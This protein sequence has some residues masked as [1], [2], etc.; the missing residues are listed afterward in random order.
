MST[1]T[2]KMERALLAPL[3]LGCAV[4]V[5]AASDITMFVGEAKVLEEPGVRRLAVGNGRIVNASLLDDRQILLLGEQTGESSIHVW[6][7]KGG[8]TSYDVT[9]IP[10][11]ASRLLG[12]VRS[13]FGEKSKV[14]IRL[15]GDKLVLEGN[16]LSEDEA[17]R[18]AE[19]SRRYPQIVNLISRVGLEKMVYTDVRIMEIRKTTLRDLGILWNTRNVTGPQYGVI[20]DIHRGS[21]FT[22]SP[23][24]TG[25][26]D[27]PGIGIRNRIAPFSSYFGISTSITSMLNFAVT[28]G[29]AVI[30]AEPKLTCK[31]GASAKFLA[32][33]EVPIPV[34]TGFG[35]VSVQFKPYGVKLE[36][37]PQV[38]DTGVISTKV[39]AEL[40]AVDPQLTVN[41]IPAFLTRRADTEVNLHEGETL[42]LSGLLNQS[43]TK[44]LNKI[45]G[46][47][48]VP[49]LGELF[50]S[51]Q[52]RNDKTELVIFITPRIITPDS[53]ANKQAV[54]S[55][56]AKRTTKDDQIRF[57]E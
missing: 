50:R 32:G 45:P 6:S 26:A 57:A 48:D 47:G 3:L 51:R 38:S 17:A 15:V 35:Q 16:D 39:L 19:I 24:G 10:A 55:A 12:E 2:K 25:L 5:H 43:A 33:G 49:V 22:P 13:M 36:V 52:F 34:S 27:V 37:S 7:R 29:D 30:L 44:T 1:Q 8:E 20:G 56:K 41:T 42:V 4:A 28:N 14:N 40:S 21:A 54:S 9:V 53:D 46:I 31:S 11:S 18:L 23:G